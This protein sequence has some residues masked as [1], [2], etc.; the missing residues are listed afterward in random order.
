MFVFYITGKTL[1]TH[2]LQILVTINILSGKLG[3][4][5]LFPSTCGQNMSLNMD[6]VYCQ[7]SVNLL[8]QVQTIP[9]DA[10]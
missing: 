5:H 9:Q 8:G 4:K 6:R 3:G 1:K 10:F 2:L 7:K